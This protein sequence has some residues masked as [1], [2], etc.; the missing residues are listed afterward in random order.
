MR[1]RGRGPLPDLKAMKIQVSHLEPSY[2][3]PIKLKAAENMISKEALVT[4]L[5]KLLVD[6]GEVAR[7]VVERARKFALS[8]RST[9][10]SGVYV[11]SRD[12]WAR[13]REVALREG[14]DAVVLLH[15]LFDKFLRD[16]EFRE[17]AI[18]LGKEIY[19]QHKEYIRKM[20]M[21]GLANVETEL[22]L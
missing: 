19:R 7:D 4:A 10:T 16:S 5:V 20:K 9:R 22:E 21:R 14:I 12:V 18:A 3:I 15:A 17:R 8:P 2:V 6:D 11:L 13:F 1:R